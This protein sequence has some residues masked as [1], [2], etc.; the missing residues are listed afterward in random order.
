[1][2]MV[3]EGSRVHIGGDF[4]TGGVKWV[5]GNSLLFKRGFF[6]GML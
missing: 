3:V 2:M 6:T 5:E 4:S 1:M